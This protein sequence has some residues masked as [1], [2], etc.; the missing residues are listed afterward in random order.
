MS[1]F[2][3]DLRIVLRQL[4]RAPLF[5][6]AAV[7]TLGLGIGANTAIFSTLDALLL[8]MLPVRDAGHV[9]T[10]TLE[11]G[12]TQPPN[13]SGTGFGNT[14]F[15]FPVFERLRERTDVF[16]AL[17]AHV[18]LG[19]G[20][21]AVRVGDTP[22]ERAGEEVSGNYFSGLG[23]PMESGRGLTDDEERTH[24]QVAV[25][26]DRFWQEAFGGAPDVIG[27]TLFVKGVPLTVVGVT[28]PAFH[29]VSYLGG[30][31]F[32]IPLQTRPELAAW[33][34]TKESL[35]GS[36]KWWAVPMVARLRAGMTPV[37]AVH[38]LQASFW[39]AS[40]ES[41]GKLDRA[42]WP[43]TL[44]FTAVRG[45][46]GAEGRY[47]PALRIMMTLVA[48]VLLIACTNVALLI[49]ARNHARRRE[50]AVRLALGA[51]SQ[52]LL[53]QFLIE[54]VLLVGAGSLLG[55]ALAM[56]VTH[57]LAVWAHI[58]TGLAPDSAVL[59][60][61]LLVATVTALVFGLVPLRGMLRL[62]LDDELKAGRQMSGV[63]RAQTFAGNAAMA[64]QVAL[65]FTL[66]TASALAVRSLLHF[67]ERD[68]GMDAQRVLVFD[69]T[70]QQV[71]TDTQ[72]LGFYT[73][74]M[75]RLEGV[76]GVE[77]A[78][79]VRFRPGSSW[80]MSGGI[81]LDGVL[82]HEASGAK[83][84]ISANDVGPGYFSTMGIGLLQGRSIEEGDRDGAP[85]VAVVNEEFAQRYL[86]NG[87]LGHRIDQDPGYLIVGVVKDS[88]YKNVTEN[89]R[90]TVYYSLAQ[91]GM[92][93]QVTVAVRA[94]GNPMALLPDV[95]RAVREIDP[96]IPLQKPMTEETQ[97]AESY[98]V[99]R[100]FSRL[101]VGFGL[102]AA[103][104]VATGLY[105]TL[106]YR[107]QRRRA[108]IGV[109]MALGAERGRIVVMVLGESLRMAGGGL[110]LGAPLCVMIAHLLRS[111]L[112]QLDP[113]DPFSLSV[114][115]CL[116]VLVA[117]LAALVPARR[118][119]S[120]DPMEALRV[121]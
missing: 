20:K 76:P 68:L 42:K 36:P 104:L 92:M 41:A 90:P 98:L 110:L 21:V 48:L 74:L 69:V 15:A 22:D 86:K 10:V 12:G 59:G 11:H 23:A 61:T 2:L 77:S 28:A 116:T 52:Q 93:G 53:R 34:D 29:G 71:T 54:S 100:L 24:A 3:R 26:S 78:S 55:W 89:T 4:G 117:V 6:L 16:D 49:T 19:G 33:G 75:Q 1:G 46:L 47:G 72:A 118:A 70:P 111:Q 17:I 37:A 97:F 120:L 82:L 14:S 50:F 66:L 44:G 102:L 56:M 13:T 91:R 101:A 112:Y 81:H 8:R 57:A 32:W 25:I 115:L 107:V 105:G 96:S 79:L 83:A 106:A 113:L 65:C 58:E 9:Y 121:E 119:A 109:R 64:V 30:V 38:A 103:V 7:I 45:V 85:L 60:V 35:Y 84:G 31:D 88:K 73:R 114:A 108:E 27:R 80:L 43:A 95:S 18:P 40:E 94:G 5:A 51:N 62:D 39:Q 67:E 99:P 87:A 63:S